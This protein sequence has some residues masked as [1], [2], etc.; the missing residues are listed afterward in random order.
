MILFSLV[1]TP[2]PKSRCPAHISLDFAGKASIAV[3]VD[4]LLLGYPAWPQAPGLW[5]CQHRDR[6]GGDVE[7]E[8]MATRHTSKQAKP[9]AET[10][11][12]TGVKNGP[13]VKREREP[14]NARETVRL[15]GGS[16]RSSGCG[17][18][19]RPLAGGEIP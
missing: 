4:D 16:E 9:K 13:V 14:H 8:A 10:K 11:A 17:R 2:R 6:C 15:C 1:Q 3:G 12:K 18:E 5:R 7:N 19:R